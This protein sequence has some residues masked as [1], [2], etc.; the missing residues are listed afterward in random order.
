MASRIGASAAA[1]DDMSPRE[2]AALVA[3]VKRELAMPD[4]DLVTFSSAVWKHMQAQ[5]MTSSRFTRATG[6]SRFVYSDIKTNTKKRWEFITALSICV[7]LGL[8]L[9]ETEEAMANAG[10]EIRKT[11]NEE[12]RLYYKLLQRFQGKPVWFWNNIL[13]EL[14]MRLLGTAAYKKD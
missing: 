11:D 4:P 12:H 14:D 13:S 10:Y 7:G 5:K 6:L 2:F 3:D 9:L 1:R 8:S